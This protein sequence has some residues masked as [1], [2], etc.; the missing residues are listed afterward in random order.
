MR[1]DKNHLLVT[2]CALTLISSYRWNGSGT[3]NSTKHLNLVRRREKKK[4]ILSEH[5]LKYIIIMNEWKNHERQ[6]NAWNTNVSHYSVSILS[7]LSLWIVF[8]WVFHSVAAVFFLNFSYFVNFFFRYGCHC[9]HIDNLKNI[10]WSQAFSM[11]WRIPLY[12]CYANRSERLL[13]TKL[14]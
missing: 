13:I 14:K 5:S 9:N 7:V 6:K 3:P 11:E 2:L 8:H 4:N 10:T 1:N 12:R